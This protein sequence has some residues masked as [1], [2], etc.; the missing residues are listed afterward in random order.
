MTEK[1]QSDSA[2]GHLRVVELG[3]IPASYA[4]RW[5]ADL[6]ADVIKVEPPGGDPNRMLPP[7][8]GNITDPERSLAFIHAN[9]NKRSIVL[10]LARETDRDTFTKLL[11]SAN[12]LV[13]ATPLGYLE[14]LG[15]DDE[16]LRNKFPSTVIVSITA[17]GRTGPYRQYKGS[18]AI[19]N[20]TG[21]FLY[22]QG[23]DTKGQCTAP[24]HLAYQM[25][26]AMAAML[27]LAGLRHVRVTGAGQRIDMSLQEALTFAN[28]SS[29]ARYSRENR[30]ERRPGA[31]AYGGAGTNIYRCK[32]GRYVH[33]TTNM[34]HMWKEFAQNWMTD[35]SLAGPEWESPRYRDQHGEEVSNAF[36]NFI[37]QFDADDFANQAQARHLAAAP[38]NTIGQFVD[39]E[40]NRAREWLQEIE[41]PAIGKYK[42][43]GAP[44]RLSLTPMRVR[45]PAPLLDQHR[46]EILAE[47][48]KWPASRIPQPKSE[49]ARQ[50]MLAGLR[51]ADLTQQYAGPLGTE[52]LAYYGLEVVKIETGTIPSKEREAAVHACMNRAKLG[53]TLNLRNP[54]GK[55]LFRQLVA[56]SDV[57]VDNF[58]SGALERL[59]FGFEVLQK[60]NPG[61]VQVVMPGWGLTGPLKSWVA[62]GWQLL[63][64]T[65]IM[66]LWGYPDSPMETRC[67]IAWPDRVGSVTMTLGVLAAL[68]YQ[69]RTGNGQFIEAGMLE[70]QG[71]MMG[72]AILDYIVNGNEWDALGYREILGEPYAPYGCYPCRGDD[73]WIIIA[74]AGDEQWQSMVKLMSANSW[75]ADEKYGCAAGRKQFRNELDQ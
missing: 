60:I 74:C 24:S 26:G 21:G 22:G 66:R 29:I 38:L 72:P 20:A 40:Q 4:T 41:H 43:P 68:E 46:K 6:G 5:L 42:A 3:D 50:P 15:F 69:A 2:L 51:M 44:M 34:P 67:K 28:S 55:E 13:E 14:N 65:G 71:S 53:C 63:A 61:V 45:R 19:A 39:C 47:L 7:F 58:S 57:V 11:G 35:K 31:K 52:L 48:E 16:T 36:A 17:F 32:D 12:L 73:S 54:E 23:D 9:T 70:A 59:G 1:A 75:A 27:A 30:L 49:S 8:A 18:D 56:R 37:G 62:W 64:Y 33:F 10:D 25:A